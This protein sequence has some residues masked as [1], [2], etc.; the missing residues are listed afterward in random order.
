[1]VNFKEYHDTSFEDE[2]TPTIH[3]RLGNSNKYL[4][5]EGYEVIT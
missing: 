3:L 2:L 5:K 4:E 1:V